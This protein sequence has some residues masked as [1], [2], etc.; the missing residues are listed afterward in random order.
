MA[1]PDARDDILGSY[2][3]VKCLEKGINSLIF[4]VSLAMF[5][6]VRLIS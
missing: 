3:T 5:L 2:R 1:S 6:M 4:L